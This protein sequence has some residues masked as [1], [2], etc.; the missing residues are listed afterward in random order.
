MG[1]N[2]STSP[3]SSAFGRLPSQMRARNTSWQYMLF[4]TSDWVL[5][6]LTS[7]QLMKIRK[8]TS[9][10]NFQHYSAQNKHARLYPPSGEPLTKKA[11]F[12]HVQN[13]DCKHVGIRKPCPE[14]HNILIFVQ[15][16]SFRSSFGW[17][18]TALTLLIVL[19]RAIKKHQIL[20]Q[21]TH[22]PGLAAFGN[23]G[24]SDLHPMTIAP[25]PPELMKERVNQT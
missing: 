6:D 16:K 11:R 9:Q 18:L 14:H 1:R 15:S 10:L 21:Q 7:Q 17:R 8:T 24:I 23:I 3:H 25:F 2:V 13:Q 4:S 20:T 5:R 12:E 22:S 19:E